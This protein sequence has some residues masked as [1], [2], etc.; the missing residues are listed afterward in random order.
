MGNYYGYMRINTTDKNELQK[1][2]RQEGSLRHYADVHDFKYV[3][4]ARDDAPGE[5]FASRERWNM[6][7]KEVSSGDSIIFKEIS[8]FASEA[9]AGYNKYLELFERNVELVFIDNDNL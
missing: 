2:A 1:Y 3:M 6:I 7:E 4:I 8:R 5:E 9:E